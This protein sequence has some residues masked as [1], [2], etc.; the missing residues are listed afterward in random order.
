MPHRKINTRPGIKVEIWET[1]FR[2]E[3]ASHTLSIGKDFTDQAVRDMVCAVYDKCL[4]DCKRKAANI[5]AERV[6][7]DLRKTLEA[8]DEW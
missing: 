5:L 1:C 4:E 8:D 6:E 2:V 3:G 7:Q